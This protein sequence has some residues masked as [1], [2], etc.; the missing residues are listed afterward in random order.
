MTVKHFIIQQMHKY[1]ICRYDWNYK[2]FESAPT[3]FGSQ[4]IHHQGALYSAWLKLQ[5]WF[6]RV[7]WHGQGRCY[8]SI[9]WPDVCVCV[10]VVHCIGRPSYTVN[11][12]HAQPVR[13][14]CH[15]TD[16]VHVNGCDRTITVIFSQALYKAPWWWI[17]YDPKHVG[18]LL[19][20]ICSFSGNSNCRRFGTHYRFHLHRQVNF[21]HLPMKMEPTVSSKTSAIR[22]Q[23][24][25]NYPKRNKLHLEHGKS[26]KTTLLNIL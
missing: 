26:L 16:H 4:R 20:I 18:A 8:G 14:C 15:N 11:Y 21:L 2:I 24:P 22:T 23:T 13:I 12:T 3:C 17:L 5:E 25:G 6:C 10:C 7:R 1:I 9:L 19:N